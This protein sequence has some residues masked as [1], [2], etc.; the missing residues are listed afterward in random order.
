MALLRAHDQV[1]RDSVRHHRGSEVK[2]TGDGLMAAFLSVVGAIQS[3][4]EIQQRLAERNDAEGP[5]VRV[6][7]GLA[8][9]EPVTE[10]DDLF[11][12]AVQLAARLCAKAEPGS[13]LVSSAVRDLALG[14]GFTFRNR[15]KVRLRGF[16]SPMPAFEVAWT[17]AA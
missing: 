2:H 17:T 10:R 11:G 4:V 5:S 13:I 8:A 15:G 7:I 9:G 12:A 16:D 14:K 1:I 6:R 3:A